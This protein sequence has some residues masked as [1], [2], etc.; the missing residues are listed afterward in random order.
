M[1]FQ[2]R[3]HCRRA[4]LSSNRGAHTSCIRPGLQLLLKINSTQTHFPFQMA[5]QARLLAERRRGG[6]RARPVRRAKAQRGGRAARRRRPWFARRQVYSKK[7]FLICGKIFWPIQG[8]VYNPIFLIWLTKNQERIWIKAD[9]VTMIMPRRRFLLNI[10]RSVRLWLV[11]YKHRYL[12][13][14][15]VI[16][17]KFSLIG[18]LISRARAPWPGER[19]S[20]KNLTWSKTANSHNQWILFMSNRLSLTI[21]LAFLFLKQEHDIFHF[22]VLIITSLRTDRGLKERR[23]DINSGAGCTWVDLG[24]TRDPAC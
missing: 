17:S 7:E 6:L 13:L 23:A 2:D 18:L 14:Y 24:S 12:S 10:K 15:V 19:K 4:G 22:L 20:K 1:I 16:H 9:E 5:R 21:A 3:V 8:Q 11:L